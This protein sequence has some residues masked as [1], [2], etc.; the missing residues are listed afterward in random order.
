ME[1]EF[2]GLQEPTVV[3]DNQVVEE[4]VEVTPDTVVEPEGNEVT[5]SPEEP[6]PQYTSEEIAEILKSDQEVDT[7]RLS[8]EGKA[9]MK[10][11]QRGFTPKL[12]EAAEVRRELA[13]LRKAMEEAKP[14][15]APETIEEAYDQDPKGVIEHINQEIR[16]LA[17]D[18]VNNFGQVKELELLKEQ[19]RDRELAKVQSENVKV[20][21]VAKVQQAMVQA[22]PDIQTKGPELSKFAVEVLGY[23][24]EELVHNSNPT[25]V[26][27]DA[28]RFVQRINT[29]YE[30]MNAVKSLPAKQQKAKPTKVETPGQQHTP[31]APDRVGELKSKAMSGEASWSDYFTSLEE[32]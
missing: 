14:K 15:A 21:E 12:E 16:N 3:E 19:L 7:S 13:E 5:P 18:P 24:Q 32:D 31:P 26:G 30:K 10:A 2:E 28:V 11:M 8:A 20:K 25:T 9:V 4:E 6:K 23:T 1:E 27:M 17:A 22:V 29:A